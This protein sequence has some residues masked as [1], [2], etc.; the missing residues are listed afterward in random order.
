MR[1][2]AGTLRRRTLEAPAGMETRPTSDRLRETLFNVLAPRME[3]ARFLDLYA[4]SGAVGIEAVSRGAE[5]VV[6]V[7][8]AAAALKVL[9]ANLESLGLRGGVRVEAVSVAAFLKKVRAVSAGFVFDIVFMDPPYD[10]EDEYTLTL[11][12]LGGEGLRLLAPDAVLI[13]EHRRKEKL[14]ER[15]GVL[16]RTRVLE[17]GDA[18]LSFYRAVVSSQSSVAS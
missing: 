11:G 9:R 6:M 7:E 17:Q 15:Y 14:E 2:I 16:E 12:L 4:G 18:G 8:R 3:G 10:A 5:R 1:V 13:A